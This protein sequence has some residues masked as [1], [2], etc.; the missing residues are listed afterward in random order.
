M[1]K[2][3]LSAPIVPPRGRF[4]SCLDR[5][6]SSRMTVGEGRQ[7]AR[8]PQPT[9]LIGGQAG[10]ATFVSRSGVRVDKNTSQSDS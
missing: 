10:A 8:G 6:I 1:R 3:D 7:V 9:I 5:Q 2:A 4:I